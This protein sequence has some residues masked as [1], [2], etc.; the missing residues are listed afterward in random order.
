MI[1]SFEEVYDRLYPQL[2]NPC[3]LWKAATIREW[4][5]DLMTAH[6]HELERR[7]REQYARGYDDGRR[8]MDARHYAVALRLQDLTFDGGSHENLRKIAYTIYPCATEW[9]CES[10][11]GLR[12]ELVRLMGG[13]GKPSSG[14][15][16]SADFGK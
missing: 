9:T 12:D 6:D 10:S 1:E 11:E 3:A 15:A 14:F 8:S 4:L 16:K 5:D 7:M 2:H 13:V